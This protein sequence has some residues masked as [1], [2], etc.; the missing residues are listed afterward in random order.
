MWKICNPLCHKLLLLCIL[1]K[2]GVRFPCRD[3]TLIVPFLNFSVVCAFNKKSIFLFEQI[4]RNFLKSNFL[5]VRFMPPYIT[6]RV[7][8]KYNFTNDNRK[9]NL[10]C[11][12]HNKLADFP[13]ENKLPFHFP[14][15][16]ILFT[17][18]QKYHCRL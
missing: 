3:Y 17:V 18:Q 2:M 14:G 10:S 1:V 9:C 7:R 11:K 5:S 8:S 15:I 12:K 13:F 4:N 16:N 6:R